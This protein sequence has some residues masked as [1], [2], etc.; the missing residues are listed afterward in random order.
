MSGQQERTGTEQVSDCEHQR[1]IIWHLRET[2]GILVP[3]ASGEMKH[4][5]TDTVTGSS[6]EPSGSCHHR[7][8]RVSLHETHAPRGSGIFPARNVYHV[9]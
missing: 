6:V 2:M 3:F 7:F 5:Q 4:D 1:P 9:L 8:A